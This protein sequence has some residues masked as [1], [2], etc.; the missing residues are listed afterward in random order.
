MGLQGVEQPTNRGP[1]F[2]VSPVP[3]VHLRGFI[4]DLMERLPIIGNRDDV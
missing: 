2:I 3:V 4:I 1:I